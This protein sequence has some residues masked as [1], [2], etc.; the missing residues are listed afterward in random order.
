[1]ALYFSTPSFFGCVC[2]CEFQP[3]PNKH[4]HNFRTMIGL[5]RVWINPDAGMT[6]MIKKMMKKKKKKKRMKKK[7]KKKMMMMPFNF[8]AESFFTKILVDYS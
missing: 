1:M 5:E 8:S 6:M 2:V 7:K 4:F 3:A